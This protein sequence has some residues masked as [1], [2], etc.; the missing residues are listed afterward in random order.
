MVLNMEKT[1]NNTY[2]AN[3]AELI[4]QMETGRYK[5]LQIFLRHNQSNLGLG[6]EQEYLMV[7]RDDFGVYRL[8]SVDYSEGIVQLVLSNPITG[9]PSEINLDVHDEHP[10]YI[11]ICWNDIK[12]LVYAEMT[13]DYAGE[14]LLE[15][16]TD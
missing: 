16:D 12:N 3:I 14:D 4:D 9:E 11:F 15:L 5:H 1:T 10:A 13:S 2:P 8:V 6:M 7:S